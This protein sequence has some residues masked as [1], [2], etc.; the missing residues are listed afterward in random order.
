MSEILVR[1]MEMPAACHDCVSGRYEACGI[2]LSMKGRDDLGCHL[3]PVPPHGDLIDV[4]ALRLAVFMGDCEHRTDFLE[5]ALNC[6]Q[7][8]PV[9]I[10]ASE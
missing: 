6:L 1:G 5:H 2:Y 4:N 10:P 3:S 7:N 8:A 9:I